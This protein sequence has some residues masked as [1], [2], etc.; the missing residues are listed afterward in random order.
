MSDVI[1]AQIDRSVFAAA[2][3]AVTAAQSDAEVGWIELNF[4]ET[5][6]VLMSAVSHN[7]SIQYEF[8]AEFVGQGIV[9]VSGRQLSE[10]VKQLPDEII[11]F[12]AEL[13]QKL[14][15][16]C[17]R[18]SAK[19]QLVQ[20]NSNIDIFVP[21]EGTS[22]VAK[23]SSI[24]RWVS[25]FRDFVSLDDTRFY[26]NGALIWAENVDG[27]SLHAVAS[28][29]LRLAKAEL[30]DGILPQKIGDDKVLIPKKAL[31][32]IRRV[33][34]LE[35]QKEF[36]LSW[37]EDKL[38]FALRTDNYTLLAKSIAGKYPP[39]TAAIP[40][41]ITQ[42]LQVELKSLADSVKRVLLF[43]DKNKIIS[44]GFDGPVLNV[45]SFTP[46]LKEGEEVVKLNT[47]V[48]DPF[49]VNYTGNLL[50]GILSCVHGTNVTFSWETSSR[51]VKITGEDQIGLQVFFLLVPTRF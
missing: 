8:K 33:C 15:L 10:Y 19:L 25:C 24:E 14:S 26:A 32:E 28:D 9:K 45:Q 38:F 1:Q 17:G 21:S 31:D 37:C 20:D 6:K 29:A 5:G 44:L 34:A 23:G 40:Q 48:T 42:S 39:Y 13:P 12:V 43:S 46:G 50:S 47:A 49:E 16:R 27:L 30:T 2:L 36:H 3:N 4:S 35:P 11:K 7:L 41:K 18:S 22:L 51:P